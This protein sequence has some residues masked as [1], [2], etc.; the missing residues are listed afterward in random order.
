MQTG[1][2][3][4]AALEQ[5]QPHNVDTRT[6][7]RNTMG[8]PFDLD[9]EIALVERRFNRDIAALRDKAAALEIPEPKSFGGFGHTVVTFHKMFG[10]LS[11]RTYSY[12]AIKPNNHDKWSVTGK[13][14]L[15]SVPWERVVRLLLED[16]TEK[17]RPHVIASITVMAPVLK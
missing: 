12:A 8:K 2:D 17:T 1:R 6:T 7:E 5:S 15:T 11:G 13:S 9:A 16:E 14:L 4:I 3:L 10:S